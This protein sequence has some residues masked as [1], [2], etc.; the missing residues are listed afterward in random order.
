MSACI[1]ESFVYRWLT[2]PP[3]PPGESQARIPAAVRRLAAALEVRAARWSA[4]LRRAW[5]ASGAARLARS[6]ACAGSL[7]LHLA[8]ERGG[9]AAVLWPLAAYVP[10]DYLLRHAAG[11]G[12]AA[13]A[14]DELL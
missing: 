14:W 12:T 6:P 13:A 1:H 7:V 8:R 4:A 5:E 11:A 9:A 10:V 2:A 3:A